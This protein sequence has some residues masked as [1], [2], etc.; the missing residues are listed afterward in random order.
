[1]ALPQGELVFTSGVAADTPSIVFSDPRGTLLTPPVSAPVVG[2]GG[3]GAAAPFGGFVS[4]AYGYML[5]EPDCTASVRIWDSNFVKVADL[6]TILDEVSFAA[7]S[8]NAFYVCTGTFSSVKIKKLSPL[9]G[10]VLQTWDVSSYLWPNNVDLV[11]YGL[12]VSPDGLT[13]YVFVGSNDDINQVN[14]VKFNIS[15]GVPVLISDSFLDYASLYAEWPVALTHGWLGWFTLSVNM[16]MTPNGSRLIIQYQTEFDDV[17]PNVNNVAVLWD[18]ETGEFVSVVTAPEYEAPDGMFPDAGSDS[19]WWYI[20]SLQGVSQ[21]SIS[22]G[23]QNESVEVVAVLGLAQGS[24][25]GY[26]QL[27]TIARPTVGPQVV[28]TTDGFVGYFPGSV[29]YDINGKSVPF[30]GTIPQF[31]TELYGNSE[32]QYSAA[33]TLDNHLG[34]MVVL[35][36]NSGFTGI[37]F[38][39]NDFNYVAGVNNDVYSD[40]Q[41]ASGAQDFDTPGHFYVLNDP[42]GP[43]GGLYQV[44]QKYDPDGTLVDSWTVTV[45]PS[46]WFSD[47]AISPDG[48]VAYLYNYMDTNNVIFAF[49]L[50]GAG[51]LTT[52]AT[53]AV[54]WYGWSNNTTK[55]MCCLRDGTLIMGW[56][57]SATDDSVVRRYN[58]DGSTVSTQTICSLPS[59]GQTIA[60]AADKYHYWTQQM[61]TAVDFDDWTWTWKRCIVSTG[62]V[63]S[64]WTTNGVFEGIFLT[65]NNFTYIS[66]VPFVLPAPV[67][68]PVAPAPIVPCTPQSATGNG[69][70]GKAGCN[71]GGTGWTSVYADGPVAD[72]PSHPDPT[73]G[74]SLFGKREIDIW[75][76]LVHTDYPSGDKTT[77]RRSFASLDD[78]PDYEGGYK[79]EG[80]KAIGDVEHGLGNEEGA[81]E[82]SSIEVHYADQVDRLFRELEEDQE[83]EGDEIYIKAAS[84]AARIA[85]TA[86]HVFLRGIVQRPKL[87]STM[88]ASLTAVDCL[89][90]P[91]GPFGPTAKYPIH[92][93]AELL[94]SMPDLTE[95]TKKL[96]IPVLYGE[97]SDYLPTTGVSKGLIPAIWCGDF[98]LSAYDIETPPSVGIGLPELVAALQAS[99]TGGT[100]HADWDSW[101]GVADIDN[102]IAAVTVPTDYLGLAYIVGYT[103]LDYTLANFD[104]GAI[105]STD[106][107]FM[108]FGLGEWF[109]LI[110][111]FGSNLKAGVPTAQPDRELLDPDARGDI[112]APGFNWPFPNNYM[113]FTDADGRT[114]WVYGIW[115]RG[116]LR[117]DHVNGVVNITCN[118]IGMMGNDGLPVMGAHYCQQHWIENI[119]LSDWVSGDFP[120]DSDYPQFND[121]VAKV[122]STTFRVRQTFTDDAIG[123]RGLTCGWLAS[124]QKPL[125]QWFKEWNDSTESKLGTNG[126]G[127]VVVWGFDPVQDTST[128]P[129]VDH[130]TRV[131]GKVSRTTGLNRENVVSG[132]CDWD[133]DAGKFRFEAQPTADLEAIAKYK[134]NRKPGN[135][136]NSTIINVASEFSW[137]LTTRLARLGNGQAMIEWTGDIGLMDYDVS[138]TGGGS[139]Y[140]ILFTSIEG[141]GASGY[142]DTPVAVMRRKFNFRNRLTTITCLDLTGKLI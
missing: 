86:A 25:G 7:A 30:P 65:Y 55:G 103:D 41:Y 43:G 6:F 45:D 124:E 26:S 32:S 46:V 5:V 125:A 134:G 13:A 70:K 139:R 107:A 50:V 40:F 96:A 54:D 10:A 66:P 72:I 31:G 35:G 114:F 53:E 115:V 19:F 23:I 1:M 76:E 44:I 102:L 123:G 135:P 52:F 89:F 98:D 79:K 73:N 18:T 92:T 14:V 99:V 59:L 4:N 118:A 63:D 27:M 28:F 127:Q 56:Y 109:E 8:T 24:Y 2:A 129:K 113:E 130:V 140:G 87:E 121:G 111:V 77:Y 93:F 120:W 83:L 136:V 128:W 42:A 101:F 38:F 126:H 94:P 34:Y 133:E 39:D 68:V 20:D 142:V 22:L 106:W 57:D 138:F 81:F 36:H 47:L 17:S 119:L 100:A 117:D 95:D 131:F 62:G 132:A 78:R 64:S 75:I 122:N 11:P 33:V 84:P 61:N 97:K 29:L 74:E 49:D 137:V 48:T 71:T 60:P 15:S 88:D 141:T 104:G 85:G 9:S 58:P 3:N 51:G 16:I 110:Q 80:L 67:P 12:A 108:A 116:P 82:A 37:W 69:G 105:P 91:Y 90:A 21:F 112:L